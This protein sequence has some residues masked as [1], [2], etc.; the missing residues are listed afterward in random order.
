MSV[1][2]FLAVIPARAGSKGLPGKNSK[3]LNG[4]PLIFYSIDIARTILEDDDICIS[5]NDLGLIDIVQKQ[6]KI[7]V[8]FVRPEDLATD[9]AGTHEVILHAIDYYENIGKS[10]DAII[11]L[12]PTSPLRTEE[13][14]KKAIDLYM[15]DDLDMVVSVKETKSNPYFTLFEENSEGYLNQ[16]KISNYTRR[17]DCP[18]VYEYNGAIYVINVNSLK[19][20]K[21]AQFSKIKKYIMSEE[22]SID[23]DTPLDWKIAEMVLNSK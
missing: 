5:S 2:K 1:I 15:N 8:P 14:L 18:K 9:E 21:M 10:Y 17:Q 7:T 11:L 4:V 3:L 16:S 19:K 20:S 6:K 12:Q 23:I 22:H 13:N